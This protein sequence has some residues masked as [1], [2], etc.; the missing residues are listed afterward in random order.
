VRTLSWC[1]ALLNIRNRLIGCELRDYAKRR[2]WFCS[3]HRNKAHRPPRCRST[4]CIALPFSALHER[5]RVLIRLALR[6][7]WSQ[8]LTKKRALDVALFGQRWLSLFLC[9]L[10]PASVFFDEID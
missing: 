8:H 4:T 9:R 6:F 3:F 1:T 10:Q 2:R 5:R 7:G